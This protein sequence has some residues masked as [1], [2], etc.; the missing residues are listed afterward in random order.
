[1]AIDGATVVVGAPYDDDGGSDSGSAYVF[2]CA[3]S[4]VPAYATRLL[5]R[6]LCATPGADD[7]IAVAIAISLADAGADDGSAVAVA[8]SLAD[9]GADDGI[10]RAVADLLGQ[11]RRPR[12]KRLPLSQQQP[13]RRSSRRRLSFQRA[14]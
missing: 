4:D 5:Q 6:R 11:R 3:C 9:A 7:G 10:A 8:I 1:M 14:A 12:R 2:C 13:S